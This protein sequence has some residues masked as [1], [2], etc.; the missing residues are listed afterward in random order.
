VLPSLSKLLPPL[1]PPPLTSSIAVST[2]SSKHKIFMHKISPHFSIATLLLQPIVA[3]S[4][5]NC[6]LQQKVEL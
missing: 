3:L 4:L 2:T 1:S 5:F 6:L